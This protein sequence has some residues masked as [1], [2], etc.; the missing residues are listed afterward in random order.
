MRKITVVAAFTVFLTTLAPAWSQT[1]GFKT[2]SP[3]EITYTPVNINKNLAAPVPM[4]PQAASQG[5]FKRMWS[6]M[7][8]FL[9]GSKPVIPQVSPSPAMHSK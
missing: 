1:S 8:T 5:F 7:P 2:I 4:P 9:G 3:S 6:R